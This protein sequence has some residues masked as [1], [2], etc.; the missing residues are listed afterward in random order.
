MHMADALVSPIVGGVMWAATAGTVAYS[1]RKLNKDDPVESNKVPLMGVMGAFVFAVQMINFNIPG[2]GSSG[3][4]GGGLI[5][6]AMLGSHTGFMTLAVVLAVQALFFADGGLLALGCNI[7][8][9][10]FFTCFIAYPLI[11]KPIIKK[12]LTPGWITL[13]AMVAAIAG[14]QMG[15]FGV[16]LQ[17]LFSGKTELPIGTFALLMQP[18]HLAIGVVEGLVTAALLVFMHKVAPESLTGIQPITPARSGLPKKAI[19]IIAA[20]ALVCGGVL[21]WFA[22]ANPDGLEWAMVKTAGVE[23]LE[24]SAGIHETLGN[25]QETTAFLPDYGFRVNDPEHGAVEE[26]VPAWP[27][28]SAGTSL[29]GVVGGAI[30]LA[31][32][33]LAGFMLYLFKRRK[34]EREAA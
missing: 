1:V 19:A 31:I 24:S 13:A 34:R 8:N 25:V 4:L 10:G 18:I 32:T 6:A 15:A 17:T 27:A 28:V 30:T 21:S 14:L 33:G 23:E 7:F 11:F 2:T 9:L 16:V 12:G 26:T 3:H 22:S 5:L 29:A 20:L